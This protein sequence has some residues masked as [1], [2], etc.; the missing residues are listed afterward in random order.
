MLL[1]MTMF[2]RGWDFMQASGQSKR[3]RRN[4][5]AVTVRDVAKIAGVAPITVSRALNQP[6]SVSPALLKRVHDAVSKTGYVPNLMAGSLSSSKSKLIAAVVPSTVFSVFNET[7][8]HLNNALFDAGYQLMLGQ[9]Q[10]LASREEALLGAVIGRRPDGIF[11]TG[12]MKPGNAR[13]RL[14]ASGIP[15]VETWDLTSNPIDMLVGFSHL[16][17]GR[18]VANYLI[19]KGH[20]NFAV[21]RASD[22]R[23]DRRM[24]SFIQRIKKEGLAPVVVINVGSVRSLARGRQALAEIMV[25]NTKVDAVFCSSDLLALGVLTEARAR[26]IR[27]PDELAVMGF[28]GVPIVEDMV[29]A[30]STVQIN[31]AKIGAVAAQCLIARAEGQV[32]EKPIVDMGFTI[33]ERDT[34]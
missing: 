4:S 32:V 28:G 12:I 10:Y 5:G 17:I 8:E 11:L 34:T 30:L 3:S 6:D 24:S 13:K 2:S 31:A 20:R 29:P 21:V 25:L 9:S 26:N 18:S 27:I 15:V 14:L 19:E 7:I 1:I 23:A 33:L 22:E 16:E